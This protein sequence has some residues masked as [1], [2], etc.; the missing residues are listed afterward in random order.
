MR[1]PERAAQPLLARVVD[2]ATEAA[3]P[4]ALVRYSGWGEGQVRTD[5]AGRLEIPYLPGRRLPDFVT[6]DWDLPGWAR[7]RWYTPET[8]ADGRTEWRLAMH[9]APNLRVRVTEANRRDAGVGV[10]WSL[11]GPWPT[12]R[13][14]IQGGVTEVQERQLRRMTAAIDSMTPKER[15]HPQILN[16]S[17][18]RRIAKGSGTSVEEINRLLRQY[19]QMRKL[20]RKIGKADMKALKRQLGLT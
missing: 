4:G 12:Q 7:A 18:K 11:G 8:R 20:M 9:R 10:A 19:G 17:R 1:L 15:R 3:L 6:L 5:P 16:G 14:R 2:A 13:R